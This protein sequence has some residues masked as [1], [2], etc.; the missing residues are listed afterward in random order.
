[1][2][3]AE[4]IIA[5]NSIDDDDPDMPRLHYKMAPAG[6]VAVGPMLTQHDMRDW[7]AFYHDTGGAAFIH[8]RSVS[9]VEQCYQVM[10]DFYMLVYTYG[11]HP[12]IVLRAF[13][14]I[15]EYVEIIKQRGLGPAKDEPHHNPDISYGRA[16]RYP[17]PEIEIERIG[18]A[19]HVGPKPRK[20]NEQ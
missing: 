14:Y 16:A 7:T 4:T 9:H 3:A 11:I 5:W 17:L 10:L 18:Q 2:K 19:I 8:R 20:E 12:Y 13:L 6:S 15:D 1:M